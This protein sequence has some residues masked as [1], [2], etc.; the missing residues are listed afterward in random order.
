MVLMIEP[1]FC[2]A[3]NLPS[4]KRETGRCHYS[5]TSFGC[6]FVALHCLSRHYTRVCMLVSRANGP[7]PRLQPKALPRRAPERDLEELKSNGGEKNKS[8]GPIELA[9]ET[10]PENKS[11]FIV[12]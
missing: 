8:N 7:Q 11:E 6:S 5:E 10:R 4:C 9:F 12:S 3:R 1:N 2:V